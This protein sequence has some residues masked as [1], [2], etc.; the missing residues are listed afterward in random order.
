MRSRIAFVVS[1]LIFLLALPSFAASL[2]TSAWIPTW[3]PNALTAIQLNAG[4]LDESNPGWYT[5][6]A[7]GTFTK[8]YGAEDATMRAA[9]TG[10]Q[11]MPTIKNYVDGNFDAGI[12]GKIA[13]SASLRETH[14][15]ALTQ[16]VVQNAFAGIDIDYEALPAAMRNDFSTLIQLLAKKLHTAGKKLSVTVHAKTSD[17]ADWEGP[18][19]QDWL[20]IGAAA[21]SVKIMAYDKHYDGGSAGAIT[22]LDW[23]DQVAS[24]AEAALPRGKAIIGLPWYGYDWKGRSAAT[25]T[26]AEGVALAQRMG[27]TIGHDVNGEA[28]FTYADHVVFFQDAASYQKK[29]DLIVSKHPGIAGLAHW[30]AGA[31]EPAFWSTLGAVRSGG[32]STS[33]PATPA[34]QADFTLNGPLH[35]NLNAGDATSVQYSLVALNGFTSNVTLTVTQLDNLG[36]TV[37]FSVPTLGSGAPAVMQIIT[38]NQTAVGDHTVRITAKSGSL[39]HDTTVTIHVGAA[40]VVTA[41]KPVT[42]RHRAA[43]K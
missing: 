13:A 26:A 23:L 33:N 40:P 5:I 18:G 20:A 7:D 30:R 6:K 34:P 16:L 36:G 24:Y 38:S 28:T 9:M 25:V 10:T 31:E 35:V 12:V 2:K 22:P 1:T 43:K 17:A 3:D 14:T 8:N 19:G 21:D 42:T 39:S 41:P 29:V 15:D 37:A 4:K 27:A 11:L 32:A